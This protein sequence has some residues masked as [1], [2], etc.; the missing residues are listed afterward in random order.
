VKVFGRIIIV[1]VLTIGLFALGFS[2][3]DIQRGKTPNASLF[4]DL[5]GYQPPLQKVA[6]IKVF[7][8][9]FTHVQQEFFRQ[10]DPSKIKYA[11]LSGMM[12][13]LGDP[14][15]V[16]MEPKLAQEFKLETRAQFAG[17]GARLGSDPLGAKV[18][19]VFEDSP[20]SNA[21][22]KTG[23]LITSVNGKSVSGQDTSQ[24]ADQ[25]RGPVGTMVTLTISRVGVSSPI[26]LTIKR[27]QITAPT[28]TSQ[29]FED[30]IGYINISI[31]SEPSAAQFEQA[32]EK[33]DRN[34]LNGLV[35]DVRGNPGGLLESVRDILSL[36]LENKP[37][38]TLKMRGGAEERTITLVGKK[39]ESNY[40]IVVLVNEDSASASEILAGVL[41]DY[42]LAT[43]VGEHTYGKASVQNV[44]SFRD[45]SS[46]KFTI[47]R[48]YLPS[49][50][51]ISRKID[52]D[53]M[54]VSGGIKVHQEV[55][56]QDSPPPVM[57]E[58]KTDNQLARAI[59]IV[60]QKSRRSVRVEVKTE[61]P[62]EIEIVS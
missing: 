2:W 16:F 49:G 44:I 28:V 8:S 7:R 27:A 3:R 24:I 55:K 47:A 23:D 12:A 50:E 20:A 40:P 5:V 1:L 6:P 18:G 35:I 34:G 52:D 32:L 42:R 33:L 29:V 31:F 4:A 53:G 61:N 36:F 21:G 45:G 48:Y 9:G 59:E 15:T 30:G 17:I 56:L 46:A 58:P 22:V 57:G 14:H 51:D 43:L 10:V 54:Y 26:K 62:S 41:K 38:V 19:A 37:A 60:R 39:R 13:S 11:G 25:I